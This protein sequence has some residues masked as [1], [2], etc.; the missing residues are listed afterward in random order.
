VKRSFR[1][2]R[3]QR[4]DTPPTRGAIAAL[5]AALALAAALAGCG[6]G[7]K[8]ALT[9]SAAAS[10][11]KA[12]S[13]YGAQFK[14]ARVRFSFAGSDLLAAQI[15]RGLRPDVFAS[16][17]RRIADRLHA[18]GLLEAPVV[19][20][21][22]RLVLAVP[23][24]SS[25]VTGLADLEH[26]GIALAIGTAGVPVGEYTRNV[27]ARLPPGERSAVLANVRDEEPDVTGIVGK[28]TQGAV[29]AGF[30][31]ATDV[32]AAAGGL[33]AIA[34][35]AGLRPQVAYAVALVAGTTRPAQAQRFIDGLLAG[36]GRGDLIR[37]GFLAP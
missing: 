1:R 24:G 9:V 4:E 11:K 21:A 37:A 12:F 26:S 22:N 25:A 20:A 19:F 2:A 33:R 6:S 30:V 15:E 32:A 10:L 16:A 17:N 31:Y 28:L 14:S 36:A 23:A 18:K 7:G 35:P 13:S 3:T 29:Q 34:L 8:P 27:L 5:L